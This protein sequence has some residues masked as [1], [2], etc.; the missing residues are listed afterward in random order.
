ML[1]GW[2]GYGIT[3]LLHFLNLF[4]CPAL[5]LVLASENM[6]QMLAGTV[7]ANH[8]DGG[9]F[10]FADIFFFFS[11]DGCL[12]ATNLGH[13][14]GLFSFDP[15]DFVPHAQGNHRHCSYWRHLHN[16]GCLCCGD[17]RP[18]VSQCPS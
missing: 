7:S 16:D 5:Y 12:D 11:I 3:A 13:Y 9:G 8:D 1:L 15:L 4:G 6:H 14:L 18:Y 10:M 2:V 17:S